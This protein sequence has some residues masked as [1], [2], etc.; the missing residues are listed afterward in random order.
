MKTYDGVAPDAQLYAI[1]VFGKTGSTAN[2]VVIA[3]F[4]YAADPNGDWNP[5]DQLDVINMSLGGSFGQPQVLYTEAVKNLS[6]AGTVVVA[7]AG[8]ASAI[9]YIVGDPSTSDDAIS[10]AASIDGSSVNWQFASVSV[11]LT[12]TSLPLY[13]KGVE[14]SL[15][16]PLA[17][18]GPV[19]GDFVDIGD[20]SVDLSDAV[21][22]QLNGKVALIVRG[23]APFADKLK[24]AVSGGAIGAVVYNNAPGDPIPMG[25]AGKFDIP[26]IM[27]SQAQGLQFL[28]QMKT[29]PVSI[30]FKTDH[31]IEEP[32]DVD[33][34]T[35]F[36][37]KGP[38][39]EDNLI[40]PEVAAPGQNITSAAMGTGSDGVKM[41]GTSMAT[42]HMVGVIALLK[43][44]HPHLSSLEFKSLVMNTSKVLSQDSV[45]I[46][47]TLQGAGRVQVDEAITATV[48]SENPSISLGRVQLKQTKTETRTIV[49]RNLTQN[50]VTLSTAVVSVPGM[51]I[52]VPAQVT[53]PAKS[54]TEVQ[55]KFTFNMQNPQQTVFELDGRIL[56]KQGDKVMLQ[57]PAMAIRTEASLISAAAT[58]ASGSLALTN[59]SPNKGVALAFNLLGQDAPKPQPGPTEKWKN[60]DCDL[61]SA[62]YRILHKLTPSGTIDVIQFAFK[63]QKPVT[64]WI[65]CSVSAL[66]DSDGDG[67]ADQE[68][69][70]V[71]GGG[72]EGVP[73]ASFNSVVL[74][75]AKARQLRLAYEA[76]LSAGTPGKVDYTSAVLAMSDMAA[77]E[78]STLAVIEAPMS[79]LKKSADGS[80]NIKLA[81]QAEGG[82]TFQSDKF[83]G[84]TLGTWI[85]ISA[86]LQD[87]AF[88]GM[89]EL[90]EVAAGGA[91]LT[92]N[93]GPGK[94]DLV[95]Y[96][97]LNAFTH[98]GADDQLQ[99]IG[100]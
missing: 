31:I 22:A 88:Y 8:N 14:G 34:I 23:V 79:V 4:E 87:Q 59:A 97:P 21:K 1:K 28:N 24:R 80:L 41:D 58:P 86:N 84:S 82:E 5:D 61:Q 25:G 55:A 52:E 92:L 70:G 2:A 63:L 98:N 72:L 12:P 10:V 16:K 68:V 100:N 35:S 54:K 37:S 67:I 60:T 66:I 6:R 20:A 33:T 69:A 30:Q 40:K 13:V 27:V 94:Q 19:S 71:M 56:F 15:S 57:I 95:I 48:V 42:P 62:G 75:S 76:T 91:A 3:G 38:R 36:S 96:Y 81:S 50:A 18:I 9:D 73:Q 44:A 32:Q 77:F 45:A 53:V 49:L 65:M 39:S 99:V 29:G 74:D 64:T 47:I 11:L 46:P 51:T 89:D 93:K 78:Q 43:Q 26:A 17:E 85:K 83:L 90:V 7:A